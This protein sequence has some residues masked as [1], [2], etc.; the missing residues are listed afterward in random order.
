MEAAEIKNDESILLQIKDRDCVAIEAPYHNDCYNKYTKF[1]FKKEVQ[2]QQEDLA[3]TWLCQD[4][5]EPRII[6]NHEIFLLKGLFDKYI[7]HH[8][9]IQNVTTST[10]TTHRLKEKLAL[11]YPL[12]I[13]HQSKLRNK[14]MLVYA[15][16]VTAGV[17]ADE[18]ESHNILT[19]TTADEMSQDD[20]GAAP[21]N[22]NELFLKDFF[23]T[24][25]KIR[26]TLAEIKTNIPW[27]PD[28]HDLSLTNAAKVFPN[29]LINF[30]AWILGFSEEV[31]PQEQCS[32]TETQLHRVL[33]TLQAYLN[34]V[35][36]DEDEDSDFS[37]SSDSE[38]ESGE[39]SFEEETLSSEWETSVVETDSEA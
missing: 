23:Y 36:S 39:P 3:F 34:N 15:E 33:S 29:F 32:L 9:Q 22:R 7:K 2:V 35:A 1:L 8:C 28:S 30:F 4:I 14:G 38:N 18:T 5:V 25:M 37:E 17:V 19:S 13:F 31:E 6:N 20:E 11:K 10:M 21:P 24:A 27:P 16:S 26:N 12:L